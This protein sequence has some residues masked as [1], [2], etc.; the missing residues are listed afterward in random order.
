M[1]KHAKYLIAAVCVCMIGLVSAKMMP[2]RNADILTPIS[3]EVEGRIIYDQEPPL[4]FTPAAADGQ[5][6]FLQQVVDLVNEERGKSGLAP[7]TMS[8]ELN[9]A[10]GIRTKEIYTKFS[11]ERPDGSRY[12]TVL[13]ELTISYSGCG[14]NVAYGFNSPQSVMD[15]WMNSEGHRANIMN[16]KYTHIGIGYDRGSNSYHY[17]AQ[18]FAY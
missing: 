2:Q 17:W 14:E 15:A 18:M 11:H 6:P 10:A 12:R 13:D 5:S 16:E 9:E 7:L 8:V 3:E 4:A 1:K